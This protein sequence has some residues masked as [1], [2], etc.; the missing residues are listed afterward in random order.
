MFVLFRIISLPN[1][2]V[3]CLFP[4]VVKHD[5][6]SELFGFE[7]FRNEVEILPEQANAGFKH[8]HFLHAP[9]LKLLVDFER[10]Y[11]MVKDVV[12]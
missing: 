3:G 4:A 10:G 6:F 8:H 2:V 12:I 1:V 5:D 11:Q 9:V 7:D